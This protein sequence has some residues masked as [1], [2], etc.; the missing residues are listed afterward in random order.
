M[1]IDLTAAAETV[2]DTLNEALTAPRDR[3][4]LTCYVNRM[5]AEFGCNSQLRWALRW[6]DRNAPRA[7]A[8]RRRLMDRGG[9]CDCEVLFNVYPWAMTQDA[10]DPPCLGV[11][12]RGSTNP[13][14]PRHAPQPSPP[15]TPGRPNRR[16][17]RGD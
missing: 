9:F 11:K 7:Q 12:R 13:C 17:A 14:R 16:S 5:L 10:K 1:T 15:P 2:V 3:E 4:C 8:L 6:R